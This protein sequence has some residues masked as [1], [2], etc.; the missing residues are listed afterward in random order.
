M[1]FQVDD[2]VVHEVYGVGRI[3]GIEEL[4]WKKPASTSYYVVLVGDAKIWVPVESAEASHLR[5]I[6]PKDDLPSYRELFRQ[7]P[8]ELDNSRFGRTSYIQESQKHTSFRSLCETVR[9][10]SSHGHKQKLANQEN[11]FLQRVTQQLIEE[12]SI[13]AQISREQAR[14]EIETLLGDEPGLPTVAA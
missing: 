8:S 2:V 13:S 4:S 10:L 5:P 14:Q 6:T 12:W 1:L 7:K 11:I 9:D 3:T